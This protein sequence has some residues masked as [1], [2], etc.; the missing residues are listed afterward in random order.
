ML[1]LFPFRNTHDSSSIGSNTAHL[2]Y[3]S[4]P[5]QKNPFNNAI[6]YGLVQCCIR[7][8]TG[9]HIC[10]ALNQAS[11][12]RF[13]C[14]YN[15]YEVNLYIPHEPNDPICT[16]ISLTLNN[17]WVVVNTALLWPTVRVFDIYSNRSDPFNC[18]KSRL[19]QMFSSRSFG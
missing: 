5:I 18:T 17:S 16:L 9:Q 15:F 7:I 4:R 13:I 11:F 6:M 2:K 8:R 12:H 3:V 1:I 10:F 19:R 14:F